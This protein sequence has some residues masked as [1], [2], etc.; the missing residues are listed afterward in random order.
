MNHVDAVG[1]FPAMLLGYRFFLGF[2]INEGIAHVQLQTELALA[3]AIQTT[4]APFQAKRS[5]AILWTRPL[6]AAERRWHHTGHYT[7]RQNSYANDFADYL[8]NE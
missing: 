4:G 5:A 7:K 3:Q 6:L 8:K 1:L 2:A